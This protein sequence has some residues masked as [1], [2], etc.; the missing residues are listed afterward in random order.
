MPTNHLPPYWAEHLSAVL[1]APQR[2]E[3][4][5]F[6]HAW[7]RAEGG[8]AQWNPLNTTW[9]LPG[10][11]DYNSSGVKNYPRPVWGVCATAL[12]LTEPAVGP[13]TFPKLVGH[14]QA[15][16]YTAEEIANNCSTEL[17]HW[18]TDPGLVLTIL[19]GV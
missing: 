1:G 11:T 15:G 4:I 8:S 2:Q 12:T 14:L 3:T 19:G 10:A 7:A 9:D 5:R 18:G 16:T 17:R 6:L 13:L